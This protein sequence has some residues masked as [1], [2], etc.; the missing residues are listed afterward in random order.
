MKNKQIM[1]E[2]VRK[3]RKADAKPVLGAI[4]TEESIRESP[5][6]MC[7]GADCYEWLSVNYGCQ[8]GTIPFQNPA[9][10][11]TKVTHKLS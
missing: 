1:S 7:I 4:L 10:I 8:V 9:S 11:S 2:R 6:G 3:S 5:Y